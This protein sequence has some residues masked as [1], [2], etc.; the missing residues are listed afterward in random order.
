MHPY[1]SF[2]L[3]YDVNKWEDGR[4]AIIKSALVT[5]KYCK[6]TE[7]LSEHLNNYEIPDR[8]LRFANPG[9]LGEFIEVTRENLTYEFDFDDDIHCYLQFFIKCKN[10]I[11]TAGMGDTISSTGF[12]YHV[13]K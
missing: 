4:D 9:K 6:M 3:C 5:P 13:P 1:G 10:M 12:I 8:P 2:L 7:D 11:K